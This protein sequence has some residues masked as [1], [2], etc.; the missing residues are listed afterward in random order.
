MKKYILILI[1]SIFGV[2]CGKKT[3]E[4]KVLKKNLT[5]MVFASGVLKADDEF[6]LMAQSEGYIQ[7]INF[8]EGDLVKAGQI[9]A[10]IDNPQSNINVAGNSQLLKIAQDN[11]NP[12][13]P[14]FQQVSVNI[15]AAKLKVAQDE[16]QEQRFAKLLENKSIA[17]IEYENVVLTLNNSKANLKALEK[18]LENLK[19]QA[20]QQVVVQNQQLGNSAA[21]QNF[22][23]VKANIAGKIYKQK[24]D[25]GDYVKKGDII[26][27]IANNKKIYAHLNLDESNMGK[28]HLNQKLVIKLNVNADKSYNA[29]IGEI[30]PIFDEQSQSFIVKA[31]FTDN[32]DFEILGTQLEAN[33]IVGEKQNALVIPRNFLGYGNKVL[34][35]DKT[36]KNVKTGIIS[37]EYV[38]ILE[39]LK[40]NDVIFR[41]KI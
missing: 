24:K 39:G 40:E 7:K 37:S 31:F 26:A 18:Q 2:S 27:T 28:I 34:D 33:I 41:E 23:Q 22:N 38:E 16:L 4:T 5:E 14:L 25:I 8:K 30:L 12:N 10:I 6:N 1:I 15:E 32:L 13:A 21:L 35:K 19:T 36:L 3:E 17:K 29:V 20:K 9:L 11:D